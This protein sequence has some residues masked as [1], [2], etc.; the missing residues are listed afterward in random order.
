MK[1]FLRVKEVS[2][3]TCCIIL[4]VLIWKTQWLSTRRRLN[5]GFVMDAFT[6]GRYVCR[7]RLVFE[8]PISLERKILK[9]LLSNFR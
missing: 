5:V 3:L 6:R 8:V 7:V 2:M 1:S 9:C 4:R